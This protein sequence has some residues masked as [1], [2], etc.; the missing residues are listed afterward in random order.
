V[1]FI[2][3]CQKDSDN[4][5]KIADI[6]LFSDYGVEENCV[7]ATKNMFQWMDCTVELVDANYIINEGLKGFSVLCIPGGD[8]YQYSQVLSSEGIEKIKG[9]IQ[10]GGAYIG[11]CG[12]S[13]FA[14]ERVMWQG[15]QLP[16]VSMGLFPGIA[17][18][19]I[20]EII[21]G[22]TMC[23]INIVDHNHPI[24]E[25]EP[26]YEWILY[27]VGP[28]FILDES[29]DISILGRYDIG[30][31]AAILA[32]E[33]GLGKVFLIGPHP[34]FEEDSDRDGVNFNKE[35]DDQGSD[36]NLMKEAVLWCLNN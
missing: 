36:W 9:F 12:G 2:P 34:E 7:L 16:M 17:Q 10:D 29:S 1:L 24:T 21:P 3:A 13:Y 18:G 5:E 4:I 25:S 28:R 14:A 30:G 6:A 35:Y 11:I 15:N 22:C 20:D 33:Y 32:F 26:D 31:Y 23:K 27:W 19:P 8:M